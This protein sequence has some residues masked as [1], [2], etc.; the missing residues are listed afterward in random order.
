MMM[1]II[2][3]R[4]MEVIYGLEAEARKVIEEENL[5]IFLKPLCASPPPANSIMVSFA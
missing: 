4:W 2:V 1:A 3:I 5:F